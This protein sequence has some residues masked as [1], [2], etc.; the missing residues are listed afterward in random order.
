MQYGGGGIKQLE[1][2][3]DN[4]HI[5]I[6]YSIFDAIS[7]GFNK[8]IFVIRHEIEDDFRNTIGNRIEKYC[9]SKNVEVLYAFQELSYKRY[10][11]CEPLS[12]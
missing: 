1:M 9:A 8:V 7:A 4:G 12:S 6:D 3:D 2:I 10:Y 11:K 5:I